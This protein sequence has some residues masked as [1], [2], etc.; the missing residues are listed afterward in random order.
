MASTTELAAALR[1]WR[2]RLDPT[3]VGLPA[4]PGRRAS[5]LRREELADLAQVSV[6][7]LVRLEQGRATHPS[8]QV[9]AALTC[10]V[11]RTRIRIAGPRI[12]FETFVSSV[13]RRSVDAGITLVH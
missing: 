13:T 12:P 6:D 5:G 9:L 7:Y 3:E 2:D 4:G 11:A 1:A 8:D 10:G